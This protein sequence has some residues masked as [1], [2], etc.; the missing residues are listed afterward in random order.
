MKKRLA[1]QQ[2]ESRAKFVYVIERDDGAIKIGVSRNPKRRRS[3]LAVSCP[4][5]LSLAHAVKLE[6]PGMAICVEQAALALL[7]PV[8]VQG[9]WM[10]CRVELA[11]VAIETATTGS[12]E[13]RAF[14]AAELEH[15]RLE[16]EWERVNTIRHNSRRAPADLREVAERAEQT[17]GEALRTH[18]DM[19]LARFPDLICRL[20]PWRMASANIALPATKAEKRDRQMAA[21][22]PT[23]VSIYPEQW[24][25][26]RLAAERERRRL[27]I[28]RK[29]AQ[30]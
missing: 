14:V 3:Q 1:P 25:Q 2:H 18:D 10:R 27:A 17:A 4:D 26:A 20:D 24:N 19:M 28:E 8:N 21:N 5:R 6:L 9:E 30:A 16:A 13:V 23:K 15:M 12:L 7:A 11:V 22:P 29:A